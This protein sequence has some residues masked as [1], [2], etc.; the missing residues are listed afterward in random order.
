[1]PPTALARRSKQ[2][3][4]KHSMAPP[5]TNTIFIMIFSITQCRNIPLLEVQGSPYP[6]FLLAALRACLTA[7]SGQCVTV[8]AIGQCVSCW[9]VCQPGFLVTEQGEQEEKSHILGVRISDKIVAGFVTLIL[10]CNFSQYFT[11][12]PRMR[13]TWTRQPQIRRLLTIITLYI[14]NQVNSSVNISR[15]WQRQAQEVIAACDTAL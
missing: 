5:L 7:V 3:S 11:Q 6:N 9:I 1:M 2:K 4:F 14:L 10:F 13:A 8:L 12:H 15:W